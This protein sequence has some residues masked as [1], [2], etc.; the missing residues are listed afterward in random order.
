M[1]ITSDLAFLER[2]ISC[3]R[4]GLVIVTKFTSSAVIYLCGYT[5]DS[6]SKQECRYTLRCR[7]AL[8][9][10]VTQPVLPEFFTYEYYPCCL[11]FKFRLILALKGI[12]ASDAFQEMPLIEVAF[13]ANSLIPDC[14]ALIVL[15]YFML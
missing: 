11:E 1:S 10:Q 9:R 13:N 4:K 15:I 3:S 7:L 5:Q 2:P 14:S 6:P 8:T 12:F